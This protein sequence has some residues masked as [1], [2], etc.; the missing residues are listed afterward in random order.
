MRNVTKSLSLALAAVLL[1][2]AWGGTAVA[3]DPPPTA[4]VLMKLHHSNQKEI[5]MGKL[6]QKNGQSKGVKNYGK[7]LV[8]D[9]SAADKKVMALA[10]KHKVDLAAG[11]APK[12]D[13]GD[14]G[15]MGSGADFDSKFVQ[16]MLDDH[17]RDIAEANA[18][19]DST[20]D[21]KLKALL[22]GMVPTLQKHQDAAQA[23]ADAQ[24][25]TGGG[26]DAG[27]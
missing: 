23:L 12:H 18:A 14:M 24:Q 1:S 8:K 3:A 21:E 22:T 16:A 5:A 4:D 6:A 10:K 26:A 19:R 7:M 2:G 15:N 27:K 9:H 17:K 11:D 13:M 20:T 25:K